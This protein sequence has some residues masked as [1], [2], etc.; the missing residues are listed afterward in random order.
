[1]PSTVTLAVIEGRRRRGH[2]MRQDTADFIAAG[3]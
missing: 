2:T 3:I 1:M